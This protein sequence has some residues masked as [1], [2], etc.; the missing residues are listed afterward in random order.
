MIQQ[1]VEIVLNQEKSRAPSDIYPILRSSVW[2]AL[3]PRDEFGQTVDD[4]F[5][6]FPSVFDPGSIGN[7]DPI[8]FSLRVIRRRI[9]HALVS[10]LTKRII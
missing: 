4:S 7:P 10:P 9:V 2:I 3:Q 1:D 8:G 6:P 5:L